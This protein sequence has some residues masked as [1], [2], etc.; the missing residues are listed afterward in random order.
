MI[1]GDSVLGLLGDE[2]LV[3][4]D[5]LLTKILWSAEA[6]K[7]WTSARPYLWRD[8]VLAGDRHELVA[9]RSSNGVKAW[10]YTFPETIRGIGT[11]PDVL[12]VGTLKGP[13]FAYVPKL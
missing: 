9:L 4:V 13:V 5:L 10:A 7:E 1:T 11:S 2:T 12:Y 8:V 6:S 3:S